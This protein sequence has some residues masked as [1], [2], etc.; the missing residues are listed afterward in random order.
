MNW[1]LLIGLALVLA[2]AWCIFMLGRESARGSDTLAAIRALPREFPPAE[3]VAG[4][5][6]Q[7]AAGP[8]FELQASYG[9]FP[10]DTG[11]LLLL[12]ESM[13]ALDAHEREVR[14]MMDAADRQIGPV[15]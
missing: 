8:G 7:G 13:A 12:S 15:R 14:A 9:P 10:V 6:W 11:P 1:N 4:P 5:P 3:Y 2:T